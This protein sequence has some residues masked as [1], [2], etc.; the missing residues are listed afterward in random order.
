MSLQGVDVT[1]NIKNN[2]DYAQEINVMGNPSNLLDTANAT[3]E[4]R[5]DVTAFSFTNEDSVTVQYKPNN[6][7][8]FSTFTA[9]LPSNNIQGV[10]SAL[11]EL[12]IGY[13][14]AYTELGVNYVGTYN[15]NYAFGDLNIFSSTAPSQ[16]INPSFV[17]G[18]GFTVSVYA[19]VSDV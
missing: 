4:Y 6:A 3:R 19:V 8:L 16:G 15:Q 7:A 11:N 1:L 14:N 5:W 17:S 13:F 10:I 9:L 12:Q 18:T 2:R